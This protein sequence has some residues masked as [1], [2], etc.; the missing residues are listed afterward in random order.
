[1]WDPKI[2]T[3]WVE[4]MTFAIFSLFDQN[5][6]GNKGF[7]H[8]SFIPGARRCICPFDPRDTDWLEITDKD[9]DGDPVVKS[10]P[11]IAGDMDLIPDPGR[12][13]MPWSS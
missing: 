12:N 7:F 10:P 4:N 8:S 3:E 9:F 6:L 1:M 13:H 2:I 5:S 11:A